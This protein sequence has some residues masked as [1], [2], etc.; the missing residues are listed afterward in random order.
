MPNV[1][2]NPDRGGRCCKAGQRRW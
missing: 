2:V 1:R